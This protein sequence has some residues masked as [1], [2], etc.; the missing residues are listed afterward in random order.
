MER[1]DKIATA[2]AIAVLIG[3]LAHSHRRRGHN[4]NLTGVRMNTPD[5]D[6][7]QRGPA[8][9]LAALPSYRRRDD[10]A[11]PASYYTNGGAPYKPDGWAGNFE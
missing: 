2:L 1:F 11:D 9:L 7:S 5:L 6:T 4:G 10:Y 8:Y 3:V